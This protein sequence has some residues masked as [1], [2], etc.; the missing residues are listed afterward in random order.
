[1]CCAPTA[2]AVLVKHKALRY[3]SV[4][5]PPVSCRAGDGGGGVDQRERE[6]WRKGWHTNC[7]LGSRKKESVHTSEIGGRCLFATPQLFVG[8][9]S[10]QQTDWHAKGWRDSVSESPSSS[11]ITLQER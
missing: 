11:E 10:Q 5:L 2:G 4:D 3:V 8:L 7:V 1:M 6:S 9:Q